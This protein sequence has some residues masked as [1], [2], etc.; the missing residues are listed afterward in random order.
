MYRLNR[1][2]TVPPVADAGKRQPYTGIAGTRDRRG[3]VRFH[4]YAM[5]FESPCRLIP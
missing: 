3:N 5:D 2:L 4:G 1:V